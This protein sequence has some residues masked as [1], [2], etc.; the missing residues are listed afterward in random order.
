MHVKPRLLFPACH[1]SLW[2]SKVKDKRES[3]TLSTPGACD[4][5]PGLRSTV[6]APLSSAM[7]ISVVTHKLVALTWLYCCH[8]L[9]PLKL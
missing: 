7:C 5:R 4:H 1:Y 9:S 6:V 8:L 3:R 2:D